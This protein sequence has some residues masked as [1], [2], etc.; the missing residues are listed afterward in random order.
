MEKQIHQLQ[1]TIYERFQ[2]YNAANEGDV[3][4]IKSKSSNR[5]DLKYLKWMRAWQEI[6]KVD[7]EAT[8]DPILTA[9]GNVVH[10]VGTGG[11]V[12]IELCILGIKKREWYPVESMPM[13]PVAWDNITPTQVSKAIKRAMVKCAA[14]FGLASNLY[15]NDE[16]T[17]AEKDDIS[18]DITSLIN[19]ATTRD[20]L[21]QA[22]M[23]NKEIIDKTPRLL[24]Q[25]QAK[26]KELQLASI[27]K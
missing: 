19:S 7:H 20:D 24:R 5:P 12:C 1:P 14:Q 26:G 13:Q 27:N 9:D 25:F 22:Y 4:I 15:L 3:D 11:M 6:M 23:A 8:Y 2:R 18:A 21:T 16:L 10:R 17:E